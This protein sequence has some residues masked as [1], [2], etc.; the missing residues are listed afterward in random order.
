[1]GERR[2]DFVVDE[3]IFLQQFRVGL[4]LRLVEQREGVDLVGSEAGRDCR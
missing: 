3:S 1:M 4:L 2:I